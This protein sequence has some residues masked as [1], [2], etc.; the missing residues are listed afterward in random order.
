ML[1][2]LMFWSLFNAAQGN[3][4]FICRSF[5]SIFIFSFHDGMFPVLLRNMNVR[6]GSGGVF[7]FLTTHLSKCDVTK[8]AVGSDM[9]SLS[10]TSFFFYGS[11][12]PY[13]L[14]S[15]YTHFTLEHELAHMDHGIDSKRPQTND[16]SSSGFCGAAPTAHTCN[17]FQADTLFMWCRR[18]LHSPLDVNQCTF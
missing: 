10:Y 8:T 5:L 16:L 15:K 7:V 9:Q 2:L 12:V 4:G 13:I 3:K 18:T 17:Y 11:V 1:L 14:V 6:R